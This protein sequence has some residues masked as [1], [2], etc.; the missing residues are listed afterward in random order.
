MGAA[1][2]LLGVLVTHGSLGR[3]M[4]R[5]A[6]EILGPQ[7]GVVVISNTGASSDDLGRRIGEAIDESTGG[8]AFL[9]VDLLGGSCGQVCQEAIRRRPGM[10]VFSGVNLPMFLEFLHH[11]ERVDRGELRQRILRKGRDGIQCLA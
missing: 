9:F 11:R 8:A 5:T 7:R 4:L 3:E 10:V 2:P 6:E 1:P